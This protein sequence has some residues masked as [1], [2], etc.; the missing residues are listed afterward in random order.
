MTLY[1]EGNFLFKEVLYEQRMDLCKVQESMYLYLYDYQTIKSY[2]GT[3]T[4]TL[5]PVVVSIILPI[6]LNILKF[7]LCFKVTFNIRG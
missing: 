3:S 1:N 6:Y 5:C 7:L 2:L 4:S